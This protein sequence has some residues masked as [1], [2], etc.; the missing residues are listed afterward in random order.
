MD[1][2]PLALELVATQLEHMGIIPL[3][4]HGGAEAIELAREHKPAII[5]LDLMMPDLSGFDVVNAL[6][7]YPETDSI[8]IIIVTAKVVSRED[9]EMLNGNIY[10]IIEKS[11]F[12][13]QTCRREVQR[14]L[15]IKRQRSGPKDRRKRSPLIDRRQKK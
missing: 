12:N 8:P 4:A 13:S 11:E 9:R 14:A 10:K 3:S 5:M 7:K 15:K 1:D 6:Q 2:D